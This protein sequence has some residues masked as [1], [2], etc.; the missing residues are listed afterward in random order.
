MK[1]IHIV[2]ACIAAMLMMP[3]FRPSGFVPEEVNAAIV[4]SAETDGM[5]ALAERYVKLVLAMGQHDADYVDAFYGPPEWRKEA[6]AAKPSLSAI[7]ADA[8][9]VLKLLAAAPPSKDAGELTTLRHQYL[10]KQLQAL[11]ARVVML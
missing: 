7:D 2:A 1:R 10:T 6:E 9:A 11:R 4:L 3:G 5:N 8:A